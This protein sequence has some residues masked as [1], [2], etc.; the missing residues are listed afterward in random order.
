MTN[1][2]QMTKILILFGGCEELPLNGS[3]SIYV[4]CQY[5]PLFLDFSST[6]ELDYLSHT[7]MNTLMYVYVSFAY[8]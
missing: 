1:S 7:H 3:S 5:L 6:Y 8:T 2:N 4:T